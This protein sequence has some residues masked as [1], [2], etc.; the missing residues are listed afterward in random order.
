MHGPYHSRYGSGTL[1]TMENYD[2]GSREGHAE[3]KW[4]NGN[5]QASG[6]YRHGE[7]D[8]VWIFHELYGSAPIRV[9]YRKGRVVSGHEPKWATR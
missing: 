6:Q 8:G 9:V 3:Y 4:G 5:P 7:R 2:H 1:G